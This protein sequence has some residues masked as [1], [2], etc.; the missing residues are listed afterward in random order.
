MAATTQRF[1]L[2]NVLMDWTAANSATVI[3]DSTV[4]ECATQTVVDTVRNLP[5]VALIAFTQQGHVFGGFYRKPSTSTQTFVYDE[6][7]F[8]FSFETKER[9][10]PPVRF[11]PQEQCRDAAYIGFWTRYPSGLHLSLWLDSLDN[12]F[13]VADE[14]GRTMWSICALFDQTDDSEMD[15]A[16]AN[17]QCTRVVLVQLLPTAKPTTP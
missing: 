17:L 1:P 5:N 11:F 12:G 2:T 9:L 8:A 7:L 16:F 10:R 4:D 6:R 3:Y 15:D 13:E 14:K